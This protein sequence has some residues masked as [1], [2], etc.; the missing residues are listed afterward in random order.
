MKKYL[1]RSSWLIVLVLLLSTIY[2]L[3]STVSAQCQTNE[4]ET[5][6]GCIPKDP[7]GFT[8]TLYG[9]GLSLI[10]VVALLFIIFGGYQILTSQGDQEKLRK[11]RSYVVSAIIG[12]VLAVVGFALYQIIAKDVLK[13]PGFG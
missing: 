9:V 11:G 13:I 5:D 12:I 4:V 6:F 10:G 1:V 7:A 3:P 2:Y 8:S